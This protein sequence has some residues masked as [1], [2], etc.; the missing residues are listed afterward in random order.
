MIIT[1]KSSFAKKLSATHYIKSS[2]LYYNKSLIK[3]FFFKEKD[4][5][6]T[7]VGMIYGE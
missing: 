3:T 6:P 4:W 2:F 7:F 1:K 5:I